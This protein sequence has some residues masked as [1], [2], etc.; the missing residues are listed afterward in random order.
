MAEFIISFDD[1]LKNL[2]Q[3]VWIRENCEPY[4]T[5][6]G[7]YFHIFDIHYLLKELI[8][9]YNGSYSFMISQNI[10]VREFSDG[11]IISFDNDNDA[12]LFKLSDALENLNG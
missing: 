11:I 5:R 4:K 6:Y 7:S 3:F 12:V 1:D 10:D 8:L 2:D 9:K